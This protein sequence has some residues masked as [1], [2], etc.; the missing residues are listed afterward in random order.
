VWSL[1]AMVSSVVYFYVSLLIPLIILKSKLDYLNILLKL[2]LFRTLLV[3]LKHL[4]NRPCP[5]C[6]TEKSQI[7][8][9]GTNLD[10]RRHTLQAR[11]DNRLH[12]EKIDLARKWI[13]ENGYGLGSEHLKRLLEG[14]SLVP[15]R[16]RPVVHLHFNSIVNSSKNSFSKHLQPLGLDIFQMLVVDILHEFELGVWKAIFTHLL[17]LLYANGGDGIQKLNERYSI[18]IYILLFFLT[19]LL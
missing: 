11:K 13:F 5:W 10:I 14:E 12:Q 18:C 8:C 2:N 15:I 19:R 7:P 4:G 17:R 1:A 16:V 6:L 9:L 3:G